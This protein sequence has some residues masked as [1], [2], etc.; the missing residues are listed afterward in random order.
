ME[1][2]K[3]FI[4]KNIE[5]L[6]KTNKA[7]YKRIDD[8]T[9]TMSEQINKLIKHAMRL[10]GIVRDLEGKIEGKRKNKGRKVLIKKHHWNQTKLDHL[11][12]ITTNP[13][14][15]CSTC[16]PPTS[17]PNCPTALT[18]P[19]YYSKSYSTP[20]DGFHCAPSLISSTTSCSTCCRTLSLS[21]AKSATP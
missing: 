7:V 6:N 3:V 2:M 1:D 20:T 4:Q 5:D 17:C 14:S 11:N 10:E 18:A 9:A 16:Q 21:V 15:N 8:R 13:Y 12:P 19:T